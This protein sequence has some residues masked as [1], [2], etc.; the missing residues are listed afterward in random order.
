MILWYL[1]AN[2][3]FQIRKPTRVGFKFLENG[4]KVRV[5]KKSQAIIPKPKLERDYTFRDTGNALQKR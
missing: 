2:E 5:S 1:K 4:E 3:N